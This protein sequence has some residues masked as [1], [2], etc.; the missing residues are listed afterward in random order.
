MTKG[1]LR[2]AAPIGIFD[3]GVGGLTVLQ[4]IRRLMPLESIEYFGDTARTPY[5]GKDT[6][7]L[8]SHGREIIN[9]LLGKGAKI[10]VVAC[11]TISSTAF[12][13]LC[14]EFPH[15]PIVDT[16]RPAAKATLELAEENPGMKPVFIATE[17]SV[18]SGLFA[19]LVCEKTALY[20]R[21]CPL[22]APM[23]EAGLATQRNNPLLNFVA[24]T[25]LADLWGKVDTLILGC[26]HYP[27]LADALTHALGEITFINPAAATAEAVK[28][29]LFTHALQAEGTASKINYHTSGDPKKF[30]QIA[31]FIL[32]EEIEAN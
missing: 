2:E 26:K 15:V 23:I 9:F 28:N 12:E 25:Y 1:N 7:T 27:L 4:E 18:R 8:A 17:A 11:G 24:E 30:S 16:I 3:S 10:I 22:F 20:T 5:G 21:A 13:Q 32:N 29:I 6:E 14:Q 19:K 31:R